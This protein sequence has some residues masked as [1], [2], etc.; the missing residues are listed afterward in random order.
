MNRDDEHLDLLAIFH[1]VYAA[2]MAMSACFPMIYLG[3]GIALVSD[4]FDQVA[5]DQGAKVLGVILIIFATLAIILVLV[6]A[7]CVYFSGR[8]LNR[9]Q[10][11][12]Y[13]IVVTAIMLLNVPFGTCL[14]IFTVCVL[15][16]PSVEGLFEQSN[17]SLNQLEFVDDG[18]KDG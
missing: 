11:R 17:T 4:V 10:G 13:C 3:I 9:R 8:C 5:K 12:L 15:M 16:R 7:T 2:M 14:G 18:H 1:Y 6:F